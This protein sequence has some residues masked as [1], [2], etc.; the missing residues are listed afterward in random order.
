M[1][2]SASYASDW[3]KVTYTD[4]YQMFIDF[5]SISPKDKYKKAW[6]K[7]DYNTPQKLNGYEDKQYDS[8]MMLW[9]F[10]CK[11]KTMS[12]LQ[13]IQYNGL[14][15]VSS[16]TED[17]KNMKFSDVT[18]DSMAERAMSYVCYEPKNKK[19]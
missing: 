7:Y 19:K 1:F 3:Q 15:V 16:S 8:E 18:P 6:V 10:N 9:V 13:Y 17:S 14:D 12:G 2:S 4:S 5:N 11:E